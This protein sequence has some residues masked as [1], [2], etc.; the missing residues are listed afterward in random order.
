M[1]MA[2]FAE[3]DGLLLDLRQKYEADCLRFLAFVQEKDLSCAK[4]AFAK[5]SWRS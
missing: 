4:T 1:R 3:D 5:N 2:F